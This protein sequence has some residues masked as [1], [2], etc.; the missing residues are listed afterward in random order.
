MRCKDLC[1]R[2]GT[3]ALALALALLY[4]APGSAQRAPGEQGS[5]NVHV[6]SHVPLGGAR[7]LPGQEGLF[8]VESYGRRTADIEMEQDLDRPY[9][10]VASRF[11]P[12]GFSIISIEDPENA[13]VIYKWV[14]DNPMLHQGSGA[15]DGKYFKS[16]GRYYYIQSFQFTGG[17]PDSD[18]GAVIF[19]VTGLPDPSQVREVGRIQGPSQ[20][21]G[22]HNIFAY[23][24]SDGRNLL[25]A[26]IAEPAA[27]VYD[28]DMFLAG[29]PDFGLIARVPNPAPDQARGYHDYYVGY[30]PES[31]QDRFYGAGA[32]GYYVYDISDLD[33]PEFL[34]SVTNVSGIRNGHTIT[35]SPDGRYFVG[36][37]EYR[38][39]PLRIFDLKPGLDGDV[40]TI[41]RPIGAWT[42]N[43]KNFSHNHEVRWPYVFVAAL[44]DGMQVFNMMD[45]TNPYT[46]GFYDTW[47]GP[48]GT[49]VNP[50]TTFQGAWGVDVRNA[51]GIIVV[52]SFITGLWVFRMDGF[53]GWNGED[54]GMPNVS[55]VQD[56]DNGPV[57]R[58]V[59]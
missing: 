49:L 47:D 37:T 53:E 8:G 31:G 18:L 6:L 11:A 26:T 44:D 10:Y 48:D 3:T 1:A 2:P 32:G 16:G 5:R 51:D 50:A 25:F 29:D 41:T 28:L 14:V 7:P 30:H 58:P 33:N 24:H 36:E 52:S 38:T 45:P 4:V 27:H 15:L 57:S 54:W 42:A 20:E 12:S 9:V 40:P 19:D 21:G 35:P 34:T 13:E 43:W 17:G 59:S 46:V 56:W 23:K 22:F 39:A 55:S